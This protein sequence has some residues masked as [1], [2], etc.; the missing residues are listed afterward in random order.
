MS[1]AA[2]LQGYLEKTRSLTILPPVLVSILATRDDNDIDIKRLELMIESDQ[3]LVTRLLR[4]A[5]SPFYSR[6]AR[7]QVQSVNQ[8]IM[9]LGFRTVRTMVTL[10]FADSIFSAGNYAKFRKEVWEHSIAAG[11]LAQLI[12]VQCRLQK[13]EEAALLGGLMHDLGKIAL[14]AIDRK[15]YVQTLTDFLEQNRDIREIERQH[16]GVD[17]IELGAAAAVQWQLPPEIVAAIGERYAAPATQGQGVQI[18]ALAELMAK[19][20]GYGRLLDSENERYDNYCQLFGFG[21]EGEAAAR[22]EFQQRMQQHD[23]YRF[24]MAL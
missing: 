6:A 16:F 18:V 14:N 13:L 23:L 21:G 8:T 2:T 5:N 24:A 3:V 11:V 9:R 19:K 7:Q 10:A 17:N 12:A 15:K 4:L 1:D 20:S 22:L